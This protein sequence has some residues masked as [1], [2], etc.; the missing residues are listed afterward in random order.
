M[1]DYLY[2]FDAI[3]KLNHVTLFKQSPTS[4]VNHV[5]AHAHTTTKQIEINHYIHLQFF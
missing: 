4:K 2:T 5:L 1:C 3:V